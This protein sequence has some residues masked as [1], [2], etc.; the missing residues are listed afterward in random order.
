[1]VGILFNNK[2]FIYILFRFLLIT[3]YVSNIRNINKN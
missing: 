3:Q 2:N 1:M